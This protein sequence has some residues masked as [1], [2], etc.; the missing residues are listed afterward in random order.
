MLSDIWQR[1]LVHGSPCPHCVIQVSLKGESQAIRLEQ[2][3]MSGL[4]TRETRTTTLGF[5]MSDL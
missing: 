1:F 3:L 4:Q 5:A 2:A